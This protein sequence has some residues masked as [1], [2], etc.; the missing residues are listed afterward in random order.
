[1]N[2]NRAFACVVALPILFGGQVA[3]AHTGHGAEGVLAGVAHPMSGAD[4][5]LAMIAVGLW[6][7]MQGGRAAWVWPASFVGFMVVGGA[8][9]VA[10][11]QLPFVEAGILLSVLVLGAMIGL[12]ARLPVFAGAALCA[13]FAVFHGWAHGA[14]MPVD[15]SGF[16]YG[17]GFVAA[18]ATLHAV[19]L[20]AVRALGAALHSTQARLLGLGVAGGGVAL[21]LG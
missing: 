2:L 13:A 7:G 9:G 5:L 14:E 17:A 3:L 15:A 18:T 19:G 16:A 11:V 12:G 1:M 8:L 21:M 4:H 10:G 20:L 6:A